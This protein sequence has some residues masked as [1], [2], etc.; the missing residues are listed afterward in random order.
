M[1]ILECNCFGWCYYLKNSFTYLSYV[2]KYGSL[3]VMA[4]N[5]I[6]FFTF[7]FL[8]LYR[9][10]FLLFLVRLR[11]VTQSIRASASL[12][13]SINWTFFSL[14]YFSVTCS[15]EIIL[16]TFRVEIGCG[17]Q[18]LSLNRSVN[19]FDWWL[20]Y[21]YNNRKGKANILKESMTKNSDFDMIWTWGQYH[22]PPINIL[23]MI[24]Q[25]IYLFISQHW[26]KF[27]SQNSLIMQVIKST[28]FFSRWLYWDIDMKTCFFRVFLPLYF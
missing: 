13:T 10:C 1:I 23:R 2:G 20:L 28:A 24:V 8:C 18:L 7:V 15:F 17:R 4:A 5:S 26:I 6:C 25:F 12:H 21:R 19:C 9:E 3:N 16:V 22:L 14:P 11:R 27:L